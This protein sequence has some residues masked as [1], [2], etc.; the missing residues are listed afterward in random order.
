MKYNLCQLFVL[1]SVIST[2]YQ[3]YAMGGEKQESRLRTPL[4]LQK[5]L[6]CERIGSLSEMV[7]LSSDSDVVLC[8]GCFQKMTG[9]FVSCIEVSK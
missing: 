8:N 9:A 2:G 7:T 1:L 3:G 5:C 4:V 6:A